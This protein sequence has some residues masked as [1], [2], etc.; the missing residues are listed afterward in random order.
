MKVSTKRFGE[1]DIP[2]DKIIT[3]VRP[4]LGFESL[5][6]FFIVD[7]EGMAPFTWLQSVED[8]AIAFIVIN[9]RALVPDYRIEVNQNEV[10][11]LKID[12]LSKVETYAI[13]TVPADPTRVSANLQGPIV[14]NTDR[15]LAKQLVLVNSRYKVNHSL[16]D[17]MD[18]V[19]VTVEKKPEPVIA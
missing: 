12:D 5:K 1:I 2:D 6:S 4:I 18:E 7:T 17:L 14:V 19:D 3:M 16:T 9:P 11:E 8:P 15:R 10:A 13:V